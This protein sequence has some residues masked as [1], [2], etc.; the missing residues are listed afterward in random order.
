[1]KASPGNPCTKE[2]ETVPCEK[3][4]KV[5][6]HRRE[7]EP[8]NWATG[9]VYAMSPE[10]R[11]L[12]PFPRETHECLCEDCI[13]DMGKMQTFE[14]ARQSPAQ[15]QLSLQDRLKTELRENSQKDW[16]GTL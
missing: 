5:A 15:Q 11:A 4:K 3:C 14:E 16:L 6:R 13:G 10:G 7:T 12:F 8:R 2:G 1:M 9:L